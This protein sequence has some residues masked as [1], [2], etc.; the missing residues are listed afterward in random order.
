MERYGFFNA[1]V[2]DGSYDR[3]YTAEDYSNNLAMIISN[4]VLRSGDDDLRVTVSGLRTTVGA[5]RAWIKGCW[6]YND[7]P[8]TFPATT[9]PSGSSRY[10]RV[11]LRLDRTLNARKISLVYVQGIAGANPTK[12]APTR[13]ND[14]YDLVLAD[15]LI[16][17]LGASVSVTDTRS[18]PELCGWVYSTSGDGSFFTTMDNKFNEWFVEK[19]DSLMS[20][21]V[22]V[23]YGQLTTLTAIGNAVTI[24]I[25]QYDSTINQKIEVYVNG[26]K[27]HNPD[28]YTIN[29]AVITFTNN[30]VSGTEVGVYI[31]VAKD[32]TGIDSVVGDV[33][34]L[35][36][37][38]ATLENGGNESTYNYICNGIND[39]VK[40]SEMAQ[41]WLS[42]G[43]DYSSLKINVHGTFGANAAYAGNGSS[44]NP[45]HW[46]SL[47]SGEETNRRV[48]VDFS[49]CKQITIACPV[50]SYNVVFYGLRVSIIGA[51][52]VATGGAQI[53]MFSTVARAFALADKCR[54]WITSQAGYIARGGVFRDCRCSVTT[55]NDNCYCFNTLAGG[56]LRVY[57]GEHYA[58]AAT[59]KTA[60]VIYVNSAQVGA[61]VNTY[62]MCCP[63]VTRSGYVQSYAI[64]CL[65][66]DAKCSFTDTITNLEITATGQNIR[67]TIA[68]N[69]SGLL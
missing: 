25:P 69:L 53:T 42:G 61:V 43:T 50:S 3:R 24:T 8:L 62:S 63:Q 5:G 64:N 66:G 37:R 22:E 15:I 28:D 9:A 40:I 65:S 14:V 30:L 1:R 39:N 44:T 29:G 27:K 13:T 56:L 23:E 4:G 51:N 68:Q 54:F 33:T 48:I 12:P 10:D 35:Q 36:N 2:V 6:Y 49:S 57:G 21:S 55:T 19:K 34:E 32:G 20:T 45:Y 47:G 41:A 59:G 17:A 58:Y 11:F 60:S 38:V 46:L 16:G 67:G 26:L 52:V 7:T 18:D 31:T